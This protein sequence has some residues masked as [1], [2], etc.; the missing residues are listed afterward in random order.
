MS[1]VESVLWIATG[2]K[3]DFSIALRTFEARF[4]KLHGALSKAV[5]NLYGYASDEEG[6]RH[7]AT[8]AS[9]VGETEARLMLITCSAVVN[10]LIRKAEGI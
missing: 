3:D 1:A 6:V 2:S 7:G 4:G 9:E 5:N 8:E 10:Y